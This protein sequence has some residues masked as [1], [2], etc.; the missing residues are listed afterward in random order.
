MWSIARD[1]YTDFGRD[2]GKGIKLLKIILLKAETSRRGSN[3]LSFVNFFS[4]LTLE[5]FLSVAKIECEV[6]SP[7][8]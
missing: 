1:I 6:S 7:R 3:R 2:A 8:T 4:G 5:I